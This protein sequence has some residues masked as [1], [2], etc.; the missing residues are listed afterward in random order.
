MQAVQGMQ[1]HVG[2]R[3][4]DGQHALPHHVLDEMF[5]HVL[6]SMRP[7]NAM[8]ARAGGHGANQPRGH[9]PQQ[10]LVP[11]AQVLLSCRIFVLHHS[12]GEPNREVLRFLEAFLCA[13]A[14]LS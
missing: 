3:L 8:T 6:A 14:F 11:R 10:N 2:H 9:L 4:Q 5:S 12:L 13:S 1:V 7:C